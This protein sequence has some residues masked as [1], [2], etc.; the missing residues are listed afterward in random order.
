MARRVLDKNKM[1]EVLNSPENNPAISL[2]HG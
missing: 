1:G 2:M